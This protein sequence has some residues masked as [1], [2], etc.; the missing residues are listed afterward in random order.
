[1]ANG[2]VLS[3]LIRQTAE[4]A[5]D[6]LQRAQENGVPEQAIRNQLA[7]FYA[8]IEQVLVDEGRNP[9]AVHFNLV[10]IRGIVERKLQWRA[11][12]PSQE[13]D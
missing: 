4:K 7:T 8:E 3:R 11:R 12:T 13:Q 2:S 5:A 6:T 1:M 9:T 10:E